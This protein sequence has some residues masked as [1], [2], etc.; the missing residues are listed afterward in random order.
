MQIS[1]RAHLLSVLVLAA[2]SLTAIALPPP[3]PFLHQVLGRNDGTYSIK[4]P[5]HDPS[6]QPVNGTHSQVSCDLTYSYS[7]SNP[8]A[9]WELVTLNAPGAHQD[10]ATFTPAGNP[11]GLAQFALQT[12]VVLVPPFS[13]T[14]T[15][16]VAVSG[17]SY[18]GQTYLNPGMTDFDGPAG[19]DVKSLVTMPTTFNV[20]QSGACS[21]RQSVVVNASMTVAWS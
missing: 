18:I 19:S 6:T 8:T 1:I 2:L 5:A 12:V 17:L 11:M 21:V 4:S 13:S 16:S 10:V 14:G 9:N 3:S 15:Q 7:V 20:Q